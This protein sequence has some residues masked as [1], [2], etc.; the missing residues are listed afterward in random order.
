MN[1]AIEKI[2]PV[3]RDISNVIELIR[4][5][6]TNIS[7]YRHKVWIGL[8]D[9]SMIEQLI[10]AL[11]YPSE[12][13]TSLIAKI[14][15]RI[16]QALFDG[17]RNITSSRAKA[18][19]DLA[20]YGSIRPSKTTALI[21]VPN[22]K[23]VVITPVNKPDTAAPVLAVR[24][25]G[26]YVPSVAAIE[27]LTES[28]KYN[29]TL[30]LEAEAISENATK[31]DRAVARMQKEVDAQAA[32]CRRAE[33]ISSRVSFTTTIDQRIAKG[34]S[35]TRRAK[36]W[37]ERNQIPTY[38][39]RPPQAVV[40]TDALSVAI[41]IPTGPTW[42]L[43]C[44]TPDSQELNDTGRSSMTGW[45]ENDV[46][47]S[48]D[49]EQLVNDCLPSCEQVSKHEVRPDDMSVAPYLQQPDPASS[50][51]PTWPN[52][53][54]A[55]A[56]QRD[57]LLQLRQLAASVDDISA[58]NDMLANRQQRIVVHHHGYPIWRSH[59]ECLKPMTW[60]NDEV[61]NMYMTM[62]QD[63]DVLLCRDDPDRRPSHFFSSFFIERVLVLGKYTYNNVRRWTR[64]FD[65]FSK[66]KIFFPIN[67]S[68]V[69]W[70]LAMADMVSKKIEYFD[71]LAGSGE[72]FT[73]AILRWLGDV[74][75]S[76]SKQFNISDWTINNSV[77]EAPRQLNSVDCGV[78]TVMYADFLSDDLALLFSQ[79]DIPRFRIK[80]CTDILR[81]T[82]YPLIRRASRRFT[83]EDDNGPGIN[84]NNTGKNNNNNQS[85]KNNNNNNNNG[86]NSI[87]YNNNVELQDCDCN[88]DN[89]NVED[90][91]EIG[92]NV[93]STSN[94]DNNY[95]NNNN[96]KI[97]MMSMII[98]M[99]II[100]ILIMNPHITTTDVDQTPMSAM[101]I[102]EELRVLS[103][104]DRN[105]I[106][107]GYNTRDYLSL[108]DS[109]HNSKR[110]LKLLADE[111]QLDHADAG[112]VAALRVV[113]RTYYD[114]YKPLVA[115]LKRTSIPIVVEAPP[116]TRPTVSSLDNS[117][118]S[119]ISDACRGHRF[120]SSLSY[121]MKYNGVTSTP[122][123]LIEVKCCHC[124]IMTCIGAGY[125]SAHLREHCQLRVVRS[126]K[127]N[128]NAG[129]TIE[130]YNPDKGRD[131]TPVFDRPN[132]RKRGDRICQYNGLFLDGRAVD[133]V[134]PTGAT[135]EYTM[136]HSLRLADGTSCLAIDVCQDDVD[137]PRLPGIVAH[138]YIDAALLR[139]V[140]SLCNESRTP[141][142]VVMR[143]PDD[144][145]DWIFALRPIMDGEEIDIG[146]T[147]HN[148]GN[149]FT[150]YQ[151]GKGVGMTAG[152]DLQLY[153]LSNTRLSSPSIDRDNDAVQQSIP[154]A[155]IIKK[156]NAMRQDFFQRRSTASASDTVADSIT[157]STATLA[158]TVICPMSILS[159]ARP[160][161]V[162]HIVSHINSPSTSPPTIPP[163]TPASSTDT[164]EGN[165]TATSNNSV[166]I[167]STISTATMSQ[168]PSLPSVSLTV[169]AQSA[170]NSASNTT[171]SNPNSKKKKKKTKNKAGG[172]IHR[173]FK[174]APSRE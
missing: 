160:V 90:V 162:I 51:S 38:H 82:V 42:S 132:K 72:Q 65:I 94:N 24:Y 152:L 73:T 33:S 113:F 139:S 106:L 32:A 70:T 89:D 104:T 85:N 11:P 88:N 144:N 156:V 15:L 22:S 166:S 1:T 83:A 123:P 127:N 52:S 64:K 170:A 149:K 34:Q 112:T 68:N 169:V 67:I 49:E 25:T 172:N 109:C 107:D 135:R 121:S 168:P 31:R 100:I 103:D 125:C 97:I 76:N 20:K 18:H 63:R 4:A 129:L 114:N 174:P 43:Q 62:L 77:D 17:A 75:N 131:G 79:S 120:S 41:L 165:S 60:L 9:P 164:A 80:L 14:I 145:M 23:R 98:I 102:D 45:I 151:H 21:T 163:S 12:D 148:D 115:L 171:T 53:P 19:W 61:I 155:I 28:E 140:G 69:H 81:G 46:D 143:D 26:A 142:A 153:E 5:M 108:L 95:N 117:C 8:W 59:L 122:Y 84:I 66:G 39:P 55:N 154:T 56:R 27:V 96:N 57:E 124:D 86:G 13:E 119:S 29:R 101:M 173:Y 105:E 58:M 7:S 6:A 78:F 16:T 110:G 138:M 130:A 92:I 118:S 126:R 30:R 40:D 157:S 37:R 71:S 146:Y 10:D 2:G 54:A 35:V 44:P 147:G 93:N 134:Y 91:N 159:A 141:N 158:S 136:D 150:S 47:D 133:Q 74:A 128:C 137:D 87:S 116:R 167:S 48:D 36:L 99:S 3:S 111:L 161:N 50:L